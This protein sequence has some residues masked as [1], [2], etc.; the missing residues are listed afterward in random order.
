ME[1][2]LLEFTMVELAIVEPT[3]VELIIAEL[4]MYSRARNI[5][6]ILSKL[7]LKSLGID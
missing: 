1:P 6:E 5:L 2:T 4:Y 7:F 3:L